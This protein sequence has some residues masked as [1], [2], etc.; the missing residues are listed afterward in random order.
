MTRT[1][2]MLE[3]SRGGLSMHMVVDTESPRGII[4]WVH[5]N[6]FP[7][8]AEFDVPVAGH[9]MMAYM[10]EAG[11]R[12]VCFDHIGYG[13]SHGTLQASH[14]GL[15]GKAHDVYDVYTHVQKT[16]PN[17]PISIVALSTGALSV[18]SAME[19]WEIKVDR[20]L[21]LG[22]IYRMSPF[23]QRW[24]RRYRWLDPLLRLI[25]KRDPYWNFTRKSL[26]KRLLR[27]EESAISRS[28]FDV[29]C[30]TAM[31]SGGPNQSYLRSPVLVFPP[32]SWRKHHMG[33][34]LWDPLALA[35]CPVM[36]FRGERDTICTEE[37]AAEL[38]K[39]FSV[40]VF[41]GRKHDFPLYRKHDDVFHAMR[42]FWDT[43]TGRP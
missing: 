26:V 43:P 40:T 24:L 1:S 21:L 7:G 41:P 37:D 14:L 4:V 18:V 10:A 17:T 3:T 35:S 6:T 29:F 5:G 27:G 22:P 16:Y 34:P 33:D 20:L 12:G 8:I 31:E 39:H 15:D 9:S 36:V 23:L 11:Y 19:R 42:A 2:A 30:K 28:V 13:R 38:E 25:G 32:R